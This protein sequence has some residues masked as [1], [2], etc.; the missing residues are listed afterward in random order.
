MHTTTNSGMRIWNILAL[1]ILI[2]LNLSAQNVPKGLMDAMKNGNADKLSGFFHQ[3]LEMTILEKDYM[4]SKNQATRIMEDFFNNYK[5]LDFTVSF[6]G[7]K[8][9]SKYAI[10]I[11]KTEDQDFRINL[12][13]L[14]QGK[15]KLIYYI[16]IEKETDYEL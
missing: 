16:S 5:P 3:N 1:T 6:E 7:T 2:T 8:E 14:S 4:S 11:L 13:F 9:N 15:N 10:G 12:F